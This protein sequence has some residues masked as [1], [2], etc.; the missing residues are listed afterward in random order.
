MRQEI[1]RDQFGLDAWDQSRPSRCF[2]HLVNSLG[3]REITGHE[4]PPTPITEAE[5]RRRGVP[6]FGYYDSEATALPGSAALAG[7]RSVQA[8]TASRVPGQVRQARL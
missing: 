2:V 3:W 6:W 8:L 5:Y 1:Y 7:V 4:A